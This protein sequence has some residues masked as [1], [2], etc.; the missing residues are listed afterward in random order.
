MSVPLSARDHPG[1]AR[2]VHTVLAVGSQVPQGR[3]SDEVLSIPFQTG[4]GLDTIIARDILQ[5]AA[6]YADS[7][8][9]GSKAEV[10]LLDNP[11]RSWA[12]AQ[13]VLP[14]REL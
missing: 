12:A 8:H 4:A 7:P 3:R 10:V 9:C 6:M 11:D 13:G 2:R 14:R 5:K 1:G